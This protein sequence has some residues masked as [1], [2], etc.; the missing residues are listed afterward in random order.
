VG[1]T[2]KTPV[3]QALV[4]DLIELGHRPGILSR[5]YKSRLRGPVRVDLHKH[6]FADVGDEPLLHAALAPTVIARDRAAG[7]HL[8]EDIGVT[9]IVMDDGLQNPSVQ[10]TAAV[11]VID[12]AVGFGNGRVL[13]AGPLREP[14][15]DAVSR[16]SAV[17]VL[18][19]DRT[20]VDA[21]IP[22]GV[23]V[24]SARIEPLPQAAQFQGRRV[25]AFAGIGRPEKILETLA[26]LGAEVV[27]L[28]SFPDHHAYS[29]NDMMKLIERAHEMD[30]KL[31]TTEK[32]YVRLPVEARKMVSQLHVR[33]MWQSPDDVVRWLRRI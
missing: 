27:D 4:A 30:A 11:L 21:L 14:V 31:V 6:T 26:D 5:G 13:P 9:V 23:P 17:V 2:G 18:G 10:P 3:V 19:G 20:N 7:A 22:S 25:L 12:G 24:F 8:L 16:V 15:A 33:L 32:D 1:G 28:I 29:A